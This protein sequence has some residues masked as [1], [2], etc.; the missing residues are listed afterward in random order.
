[1]NSLL[2]LEG[3]IKGGDEVGAG[4]GKSGGVPDGGAS[5]LVRESMMGGGNTRS[6]GDGICGSGDDNGV[7]GDGG[8]VSYFDVHV[9]GISIIR[10]LQGIY[11]CVHARI[12]EAEGL[13][14]GYDRMQK[15]LSQL[16]QLK[17]KLE[18]EDINLKFL[19]ALP[20]SWSQESSTAG[21]A[22]EFVLMVVTFEVYPHLRV[23]AEFEFQCLG[24][25]VKKPIIENHYSDAEDEGIFD[26]GCFRS[27]TGN[28]ERL[29]DFQEFQ[30]GKVT[31]GGGEGT[32]TIQLVLHLSDL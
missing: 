12:S 13:H 10:M 21:D 15:I 11:D 7:S 8:G 28:M 9:A 27:M 18:D 1:M 24:L 19:R 32:A 20:S 17:A 5:D 30:G 4:I 16:N 23:E 6:G 2:P 29:D 31:F 25:P 3:S 14:K 26:S 22:G